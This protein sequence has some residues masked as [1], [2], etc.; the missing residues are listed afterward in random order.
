VVAFEAVMHVSRKKFRE[1][2]C[3]P[4]TDRGKSTLRLVRLL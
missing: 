1:Q 2:L 3:R 4:E